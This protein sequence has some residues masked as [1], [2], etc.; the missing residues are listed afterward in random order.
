M[1]RNR[2]FWPGL[3][4]DL[5]NL[6]QSCRACKRESASK[7]NTN[8]YNVIPPDLLQ[9]SPAEEIS[10][11]FMS[12]GT[13]SILV[14]KDRQTGYIAAKL[15]KDKTTRSAL[16]ALKMWFYSYGFS[17]TVRSD[18]GPCF[19][20]TFTN[21]LDKLGIK[22]TL[23]SAHNPQSNGGAERVCKSIREVLNKRG[24][25]RTD[26]M[27]LS[28]LCFKVNSHIQPGG[29]GSAHERFHKRCPKTLLPGTMENHVDHQ[30]M[31]RKRHQ[32][33]LIL[34]RKKGRV[35][36]DEFLVN[37]KVIIQNNVNGKWEEEGVIKAYRRAD[38]NSVQSYE[39]EM[40]SG[41]TKIRNK[42]FIKHLSKEDTQGERHVHFQLSDN[43]EPQNNNNNSDPVNLRGADT[44]RENLSGPLTR[45]RARNLGF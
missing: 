5:H 15:C 8:R 21:E 7:P 25:H 31:I 36:V 40:S 29:R 12:Y 17:N 13:Q 3:Q 1:A 6:F 43:N 9:M 44:D 23:S 19:K 33:Q 14:I 27:E 11:D 30:E 34:S 28:E 42:R 38:D 10:V 45:G 32:N 24:G 41:T 22:H 2:F 4:E 20:D 18:G 16:E 39:I 26:Q 37:D 35:A